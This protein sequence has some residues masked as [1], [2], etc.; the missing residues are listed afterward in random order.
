MCVSLSVQACV[1]GRLERQW[2][3]TVRFACKPHIHITTKYPQYLYLLKQMH[4]HVRYTDMYFIYILSGEITCGQE[5]CV[6][7]HL[8]VSDAGISPV[9]HPVGFSC[10]VAT[11]P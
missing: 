7:V 11:S 2:G 9:V 4:I 10:Y 5:T 6:C 1:N 8:L 3:S